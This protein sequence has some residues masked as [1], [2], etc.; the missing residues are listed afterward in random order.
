MPV[1]IVKPGVNAYFDVT[2]TNVDILNGSYP[3]WC[4]EHSN[5]LLD[6]ACADV[7]LSTNLDQFIT[8]NSYSTEEITNAINWILNYDFTTEGYNFAEVQ[9]AIWKLLTGLDKTFSS[10]TLASLQPGGNVIV[11]NAITAVGEGYAPNCGSYVG[12]AL[13]PSGNV[14]GNGDNTAEDSQ[15]IIIPVMM[16]CNTSDSDCEETIWAEGCYFPGN[17]WAM[18]F[19]FDNN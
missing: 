14:T 3:A 7:T 19:Q 10:Y 5:K 16:E 18:Y 12:V 1:L 15:A 13:D 8:N 9:F 4:L 11:N 6:S 2:L 17:N